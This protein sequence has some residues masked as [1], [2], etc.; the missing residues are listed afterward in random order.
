MSEHEKEMRELIEANRDQ[1]RIDKANL[2]SELVDVKARADRLFSDGASLALRHDVLRAELAHYKTLYD[3]SFK[4]GTKTEIQLREKITR[5]EA[6]HAELL[7]YLPKVPTQPYEKELAQQ[8]AA[9]TAE[10]DEIK[11]KFD[12]QYSHDTKALDTAHREIASLKSI[13]MDQMQTIARLTEEL[14]QA[15]LVNDRLRDSW[16]EDTDAL[17]AEL[18]AA[19]AELHETKIKLDQKEFTL[20]NTFNHWQEA[21]AQRDTALAVIETHARGITRLEASAKDHEDDWKRIQDAE[22]KCEKLEA[23]LA[24]AKAAYNSNACTCFSL[25]AERDAL[26]AEVELEKK[27]HAKTMEHMR[28]CNDDWRSWRNCA[29]RLA[30]LLYSDFA[31][32]QTKKALADFERINGDEK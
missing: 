10:R 9:V 8:L 30:D 6:A 12:G 24:Q 4:L 15:K 7:S 11:H 25:A 1:L 28:A 17:K 31:D 27:S 19:K 20:Q 5:L 14:A 3:E 21:M 22:R 2:E 16:R 13:E 23:E 32:E 18:A 29:A 26:K